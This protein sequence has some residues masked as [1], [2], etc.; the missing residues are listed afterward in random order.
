GHTWL[1]V[2]GENRATVGVMPEFLKTIGIITHL[3]LPRV[4]DTISQGE[5]CG[6]V[7]DRD[8][9]THRIWSPASGRV[10][11][12]NAALLEDYSLLRR[13]PYNQ[14]FLFRIETSQLEEDLKGLLQAR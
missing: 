13:S 14:G 12:V 4:N 10:V 11:E 8:Q 6:K 3:E 2:E 5:V 7:T 1:N 9:F